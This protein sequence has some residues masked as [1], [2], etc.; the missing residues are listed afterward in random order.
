MKKGDKVFLRI[1]KIYKIDKYG[2]RNYSTS[3]LAIL[4]LIFLYTIIGG[5]ALLLIYFESK[6][7]FANIKTYGDAFWALM[8]SASTIGFGDVYPVTMG[9]R[10]IVAI[11]FYIGVGLVGFVGAQ[12]VNK[13]VGFTDNSEELINN[14]NKAFSLFQSE[15]EI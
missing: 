15:Y 6:S 11:T 2:V 1:I 3:F 14:Y 4:T 8:L 9:G 10:V 13:L 5:F 12:F 7:S